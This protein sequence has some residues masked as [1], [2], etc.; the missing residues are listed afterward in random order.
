MN[1]GQLCCG[2]KQAGLGSRGT[3]CLGEGASKA[4][5]NTPVPADYPWESQALTG[6]LNPA[7]DQG[8]VTLVFFRRHVDTQKKHLP[9]CRAWFPEAAAGKQMLPT[10]HQ[11]M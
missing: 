5:G 10:D 9:I 8:L 4:M 6:V 1:W 2:E 11:F 7:A 3:A